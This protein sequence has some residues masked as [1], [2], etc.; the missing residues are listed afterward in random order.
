M[1]FLDSDTVTGDD[2][3]TYTERKNIKRVPKSENGTK[4]SNKKSIIENDESPKEQQR[5][6]YKLYIDIPFELKDQL[7]PYGIFW[8]AELKMWYFPQKSNSIDLINKL[9]KRI[10]N[11]KSLYI[12][13]IREFSMES[14]SARRKKLFRWEELESSKE[15]VYT[16]IINNINV[17]ND[18]L[19]DL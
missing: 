11:H 8:D 14:G 19:K 17:P 6:S 10:N 7:K 12:S 2:S 16:N 1:L 5:K 13:F 15:P 3:P 4:R 9:N 18:L